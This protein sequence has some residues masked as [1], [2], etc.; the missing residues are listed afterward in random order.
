MSV[1]G[2]AQGTTTSNFT[3][4]DE[5]WTVVDQN[6][7]STV[8]PGYSATGGNPGGFV[9][10]SSGTLNY[11][12]YFSAPAKFK[13]NFSFSYNQTL[14]FDMKVNVNGTDNSQPDIILRDAANAFLL[15]YQLPTKP[16]S[17]SWTTYSI[18]LN[19]ASWHLNSI[20][21]AAPTRDQF[22][23]VLANIGTFLIRMKYQTPSV[24]AI[25]GQLDNV[26]LNAITLNNPPKV[27]SFSPASGVPGTTVTITGNNF[28]STA[29]QNK[30]YFGAVA[31]SVT[32]ATA[33]QLVVTLPPGATYGPVQVVNLGTGL[34]GSSTLSFNPLF[35][36]NSDNGGRVMPASFTRGYQTILQ[37]GT[38]SSNSFGI[39]DKG[40]FDG[41]G[42]IDLIT[43]E[44]G[45]AKIFVYRNLGSTAPVST[46]CRSRTCP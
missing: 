2:L 39:M 18:P 34:Q 21:G 33:S 12:I 27:T 44:T 35:N 46:I 22:K 24:A 3:T 41:D 13:G 14:T 30:V 20:A 32:T 43:T 6:S 29:A 10:F 36:N 23:Q 4:N 31:A 1:Q 38:E 11:N 45:A 40:D 42:K 25:I 16:V 7:G 19:E 28:N 5:G 8:A 37:S 26:T 15:V 9:Q 17:A